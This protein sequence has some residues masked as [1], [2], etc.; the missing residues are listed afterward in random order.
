M[1]DGAQAGEEAAVPHFLKVTL[2]HVLSAH[3]A[4]G[5]KETRNSYGMFKGVCHAWDVLVCVIAS[6][7]RTGR[8][9]GAPPSTALGLP[10]PP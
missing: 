9:T 6:T 4:W 8:L 1:G 5:H 10:L 7:G 2:A 3:S